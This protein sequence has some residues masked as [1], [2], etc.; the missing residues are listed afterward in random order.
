MRLK[1][2]FA[3]LA[4]ISVLGL[5]LAASVTGLAGVASAQ[6]SSPTSYQATLR[7][8][9][10]NGQN[11]ASG[12]LMLTLNGNTATI[13]EQVSGL[14]AT[15]M[16]GPYPHVQH[17][18]GGAMG[19]CPTA[20]ADTNHDGVIS[21]AEGMASYGMIQ[22]TLSVTGDTSPAS[23]T[24]I[25]IAPSGSS[26]TYDRTINLDAATMASLSSGKAVMVVHGLDPATAPKA[27]S[28]EKSELVPSL[29][30][31]ATSP[32]LCGTLVAAQMS[33]VPGGGAATGSGSTQGVQ[34][35]DLIWAGGGLLGAGAVLGVYRRRLAKR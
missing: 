15:F 7:P 26:Y 12:T 16:N 31:A 11:N 9:P 10:L 28:T 24:N 17:I 34:N 8:V 25:K 32:A 35:G 27:A 13:H 19:T 4:P 20:S 18:H 30:L 29:P 23:G 14:A 6:S 21:T 1:K 33:S 22:T 3:S 2:P 5:G